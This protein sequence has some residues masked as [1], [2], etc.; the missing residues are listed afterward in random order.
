MKKRI[1]ILLFSSLSLMSYS[2][3]VQVTA[4]QLWIADRNFCT[5][6]WLYEVDARGSACLVRHHQQLHGTERGKLRKVGTT[7]TGTVW[8]NQLEL[9]SYGGRTLT[10]RRIVVRLVERESIADITFDGNKAIK[11]EELE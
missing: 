1:F 9:P 7:Q 8:E 5:L 10:V 4:Q 11:T 2:Q 3:N 6:K